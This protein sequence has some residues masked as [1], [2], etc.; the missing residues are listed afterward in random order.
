MMR[1]IAFAAAI[2]AATF[3]AGLTSAS[4]QNHHGNQPARNFLRKKSMRHM[5]HHA[6]RYH[7]PYSMRG[8]RSMHHGMWYGYSRHMH[9]HRM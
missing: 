6:T 1:K 8:Y 4:A 5:S 3:T 9:H 7:M 2:A